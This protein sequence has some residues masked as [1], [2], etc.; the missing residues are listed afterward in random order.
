MIGKVKE[1]LENIGAI[2]RRFDTE[3]I[4]PPGEETQKCRTMA[5]LETQLRELFRIN[6]IHK[7]SDSKAQ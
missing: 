6:S 1:G 3:L 2:M 7:S 4:K 5:K